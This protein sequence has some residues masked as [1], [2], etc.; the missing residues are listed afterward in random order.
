MN[1]NKPIKKIR[2]LKNDKVF[3]NFFKNNQKPLISLLDGGAYGL[4][5]TINCRRV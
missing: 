1:K 2:H 4:D 5:E 3:K